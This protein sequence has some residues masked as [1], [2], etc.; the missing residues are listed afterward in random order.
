MLSHTFDPTVWA[1]MPFHFWSVVFFVL[2]SMVGSFLNVCIH[3]MPLG[4]SI[5]SP[6]SHC[7]K[8]G[9]SIPWYLNIPLF[10]WVWLRGKCRNCKAPISVRYFLVELLNAVLFLSCWLAFGRQSTALALVYAFFL[11]GLVV[12]TF[13]DLEHL[14]IPDEITIGGMFAGFVCS[15][16][17]PALHHQSSLTGGMKRSLLGI[18]FGAGLI[19]FILRGFKLVFGRHKLALAADTRLVF[20]ETSVH[21]PENEE[22]PYEDV[23]YRRSDTIRL[24]AQT[25][26]LVDRCYKNVLVRLS[27]NLLRIG[28][29]KLNPEEVPHMEAVT[30]ELVLPREVMGLGDV[31]FMAAIGAFLGW[32]AVFFSLVVSSFVGATVGLTLVFLGRREMGSRLPYGPYIAVGA[33]LW[34][35]AG[36]EMVR[37]YQHLVL[38]MLGR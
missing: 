5:I 26:E 25:L 24:Q 33:A 35:F 18:A 9:Y 38:S 29:E 17:V 11:S 19:Y 2:G 7:P 1:A 8:C 23:F 16:V 20:T 12:A 22:I 3:R 10:T 30:S 27:P 21:L 36:P 28:E 15:F 14:I 31:K 32:K 37:W 6:P 13:I 34:I 4:E